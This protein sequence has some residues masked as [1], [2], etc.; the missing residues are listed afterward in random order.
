M[1]GGEGME[2]AL[3]VVTVFSMYKWFMWKLTAKSI[4]G[5]YLRWLEEK[6]TESPDPDTVKKYQ[7]WVIQMMVKDL[8]KSSR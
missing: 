6:N 4:A 1:R 2:I 5:A 8:F 7:K 3:G